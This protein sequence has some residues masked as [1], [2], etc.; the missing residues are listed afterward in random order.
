MQRYIRIPLI[1]FFIASSLG[2]LLRWHFIS[3]LET[4]HY[5][6]LLHAHS[7][8][9]FLGWIFNTFYLA[10]V[11][12]YLRTKWNTRYSRLFIL[13]QILVLG[14]LI[15]F[16]LQG[17]GLFSIIFSTLHTILAGV[18]LVL[19]FRDLK[20]KNLKGFSSVWFVKTSL[21]FF[22]LS[23]L[24]P[25]TL[26][27]I[28]ANDQGQSNWYYFAV[29]FYL[30][31]QYNGFFLFGVIGLFL[32]LL[33]EKNILVAK[34]KVIQAGALMAIA[35]VPA[36]FLSVLWANPGWIF[37]AIGFV[38]AC[39]QIF[40]LVLFI[41]IISRNRTPIQTAFNPFS[42]FMMRLILAAFT[43]KVVLQL[44]SV[45]PEVARLAYQFRSYV[46]AYLHLVLLGIISLFLLVWYGEK[47]FINLT[48]TKPAF[49]L[50]VVGLAGMELLLIAA[51][52]WTTVSRLPSSVLEKGIMAFSTALW[53]SAGWFTYGSFL[54]KK[55]V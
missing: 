3:P 49:I 39:L 48:N 50:F 13:L 26:G 31:F 2:L 16:P 22:L 36:Y 7:H 23:S 5:P 44:L 28:T 24:G 55:D 1:F 6:F 52:S 35:C 8:I 38:A 12:S 15:S 37:T 14:M 40:S 27:Y 43:V 9:M 51:P 25:L 53:I 32:R 18:F 47:G 54:V 20:H 33:E 42:V 11:N 21:L 34:A 29:Y 10:Y 46:I 45:Y 30:H 17:Y 19:F 4:V 41:K